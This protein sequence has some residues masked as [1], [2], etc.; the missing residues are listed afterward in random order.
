MAIPNLQT[1]TN[2]QTSSALDFNLGFGGINKTSQPI[3]MQTV[4]ALGVIGL[5]AI[6]FLKK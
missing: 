1:S 2:D 4:I 3:Q 5:A 6:Y